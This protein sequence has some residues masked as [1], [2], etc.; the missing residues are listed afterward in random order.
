M[1]SIKVQ[2]TDPDTGN[3]KYE[4]VKF[5]IAK[6]RK[7][8][9]GV[10]SE[11]IF[12]TSA[13]TV[14]STSR[15]IVDLAEAA[16]VANP[17]NPYGCAGAIYGLIKVKPTGSSIEL[18]K[19]P[20]TLGFEA[21]KPVAV[22]SSFDSTTPIAI[23]TPTSVTTTVLEFGSAVSNLIKGGF[24]VVKM[25]VPT[26]FAPIFAKEDTSWGAKALLERPNAPTTDA[27]PGSG[28]ISVTL[29]V[30][31]TKKIV[32][33]KYQ[34][35]VVSATSEPTFDP[36]VP[37]INGNR[38]ADIE[39]DPPSTGNTVQGTATTFGGGADFGGGTIVNGKYYVVAIAKDATG[40][41]NIICSG[42]SN[43]DEVTVTY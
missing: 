17:T 42:L 14:V 34:V 29:T 12:F 10:P 20:Q 15:E 38:K 3:E 16:I 11:N 19:N 4:I 32:T 18:T 43:I 9:S 1:E 41:M 21:N 6:F 25:T 37:V 26:A 5:D 22:L 27:T 8:E 23:L 36:L 33:K 7:D 39:L 2:Y 13:G 31:S 35:F 28:S 40:D 30:P 24:V